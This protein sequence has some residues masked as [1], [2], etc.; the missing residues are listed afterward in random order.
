MYRPRLADHDDTGRPAALKIVCAGACVPG[1][2]LMDPPGTRPG[3]FNSLVSNV[4][5]TH[6][7]TEN[8]NPGGGT[9]LFSQKWYTFHSH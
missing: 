2:L 3:S 5:R 6:R 1:G 7:A 8:F 4:A 9:F